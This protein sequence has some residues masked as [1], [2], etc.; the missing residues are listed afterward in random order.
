MLL[1]EILGKNNRGNEDTLVKFKSTWKNSPTKTIRV[2]EKIA[3]IVLELARQIDRDGF[4][5]NCKESLVTRQLRAIVDKIDNDE[6]GYRANSASRL[7]KELKSILEVKNAT[8]H[9]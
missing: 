1:N 6:K 4:V 7:I 9:D 2:P 8:N 3:D 5:D